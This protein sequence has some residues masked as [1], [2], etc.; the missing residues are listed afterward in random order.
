MKFFQIFVMGYT[1]KRECDMNFVLYPEHNNPE[2]VD[3]LGLMNPKY[4]A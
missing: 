1:Y 3:S 4:K 2:Y